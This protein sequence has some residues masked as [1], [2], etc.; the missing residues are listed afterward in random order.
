M[1]LSFPAF[2][3]DTRVIMADRSFSHISDIKSGDVLL[4]KGKVRLNVQFHLGGLHRIDMQYLG[5]DCAM[6]PA[7]TDPNQNVQRETFCLFLL[8]MEDPEDVIP[9]S[10]LHF[11]NKQD[12]RIV[13]P[14]WGGEPFIK[15][16]MRHPD[17]NSGYIRLRDLKIH[18][19]GSHVN[20]IEFL[21]QS[22]FNDT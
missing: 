10:D 9:V 16:L 7:S 19:N 13:D 21:E 8:V 22:D 3:P 2:H 15:D 20:R 11:K 5:R 1:D 18:K 12:I 6:L 4:G 17:F 14:Y